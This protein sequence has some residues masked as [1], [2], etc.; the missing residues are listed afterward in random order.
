MVLALQPMTTRG[1]DVFVPVVVTVGRLAAGT[2]ENIIPDGAELDVDFARLT[3][4]TTVA[5]GGQDVDWFADIAR[6]LA[7]QIPAA[8]LVELSWA[9]HLPSLERPDVT[10]ALVRDAVDAP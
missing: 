3:V 6:E 9:G 8:R 7:R 4:P 2:T 10:S 1:V 5:F